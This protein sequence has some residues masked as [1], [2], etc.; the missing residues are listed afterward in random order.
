[1]HRLGQL[2]VRILPPFPGNTLV[3]V[4]TTPEPPMLSEDMTDVARVAHIAAAY[5]AVSLHR[6]GKVSLFMLQGDATKHRSFGT[7]FNVA[8]IM[9]AARMSPIA[10]ALWKADWWRSEARKPRVP[11]VSMLFSKR[12]LDEHASWFERDK[13][14]YSGGRRVLGLKHRELAEDWEAMWRDLRRERPQNREELARVVEATFPGDS[15]ET[16]LREA[17]FEAAMIQQQIDAKVQAGEVLW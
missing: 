10:W 5:R 1:M 7:L 17:K 6:F 2:G 16:R 15:F 8:G 13:G 11:H 12:S 3:P 14:S 9:S 4:A